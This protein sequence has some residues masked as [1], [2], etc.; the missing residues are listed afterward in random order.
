MAF[1]FRK[2]KNLETLPIKNWDISPKTQVLKRLKNI[3]QFSKSKY[4]S[5]NN[6]SIPFLSNTEKLLEKT[7]ETPGPGSYNIENSPENFIHKQYIKNNIDKYK[8]SLYDSYSI[9]KSISFRLNKKSTPG[10]GEYNPGKYE[11]FGEKIKNKIKNKINKSY[12]LYNNN[13]QNIDNFT[14]IIKKKS[15]KRKNSDEKYKYNSNN[16]GTVC[17]IE[18]DNKYL[19][20]RV[21][22]YTIKEL[23]TNLILN[24]KIRNKNYENNNFSTSKISNF[25]N[26]LNN[27]M[28]KSQMNLTNNNSFYSKTSLNINSNQFNKSKIY[29]NKQIIEKMKETNPK[30]NFK[31]TTELQESNYYLN[32]FINS[33]YFSQNPGPGYYFN[34]PIKNNKNLISNYI[35]K[36][37]SIPAST[38]K[39]LIKNDLY[40]HNESIK[41][42]E[43]NK[44]NN[45]IKQS[46]S[47]YELQSDIIKQNSEKEKKIYTKNKRFLLLN[48]LLKLMKL[49]EKANEKEKE[50]K[51]ILFDNINNNKEIQEYNYPIN[52][53][54]NFNI[55]SDNILNNFNTMKIRFED[56][57][58]YQNEI[59]KNDNPGPGKYQI[60]YNKSIFKRNKDIIEKHSLKK[61]FKEKK[62]YFDEIKNT[63]PPVGTYQSQF[64][65]TIGF[66]NLMAC[67]KF[68]ENPIRNG[69]SER[70][71]AIT[72][73]KIKE[74][75]TK[76]NKS[77]SMLSPFSYFKNFDNKNQKN[78]NKNICFGSKSEKN[79]KPTKK[80]EVGPGDYNIDLNSNW[81]KR[82]YNVLFV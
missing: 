51:N 8:E 52:K 41:E 28:N 2:E 79:I 12:S 35:Q 25:I 57:F 45:N 30:N 38:K 1:V 42:N 36:S 77:K 49:K 17:D 55:S 46:K 10:P 47:F 76:E 3:S 4:D 13:F 5:F 65:N 60:F 56:P 82:S 24:Q 43:K 71:K 40:I 18:K 15:K 64:Y 20:K 16:K 44:I 75:K 53:N 39:N 19:T 22:S 29:K 80:N 50:N 68:R 74:M 73:R 33:K 78:Y 63:N 31:I 7:E 62:F 54:K 9:L 59:Y 37:H 21:Q 70:I 34:K 48:D 72:D 81:I 61:D 67:Q 58:G 69:F 26:D 32:E 11:L 6:N 27:K 23:F 66:N 14:K